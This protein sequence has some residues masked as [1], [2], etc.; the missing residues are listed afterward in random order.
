MPLDSSEQLNPHGFSLDISCINTTAVRVTDTSLDVEPLP[1]D[2]QSLNCTSESQQS[3]TIAPEFPP[4]Q[5]SRS[6]LIH[7]SYSSFQREHSTL[8]HEHSTL[9]QSETSTEKDNKIGKH[10]ICNMDYYNLDH[11]NAS[12]ISALIQAC[13][14]G[15]TETITNLLILKIPSVVTCIQQKLLEDIQAVT[16]IAS[17]KKTSVHRTMRSMERLSACDVPHDRGNGPQMPISLG[18]S[19]DSGSPTV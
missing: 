3:S 11:L 14:T 10:G 4:Q 15:D 18:Y 17:L 1:A 13:Q 6:H 2:H 5:S 12:Q 8:H 16:T 19:A 9:Q 7:H